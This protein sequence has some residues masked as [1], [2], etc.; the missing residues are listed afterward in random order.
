LR[1]LFFS[2]KIEKENGKASA[3]HLDRPAAMAFVVVKPLRAT[4][5]PLWRIC[6]DIPNFYTFSYSKELGGYPHEKPLRW[7]QLLTAAK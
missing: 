5:A 4:S 7:L 3:C 2:A 6:E 1:E